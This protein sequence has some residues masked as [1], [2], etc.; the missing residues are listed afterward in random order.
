LRN[1]K[2]STEFTILTADKCIASVI[3]NTVD[4]KRKITSILEDPSHRRLARDPTES[5]EI[6]T[7]LLLKK[8]TVTDDISKQLRPSGSRP[9]I[10]YGLP[11]IHKEGVPLRPIVNNIGAPTYQLSKYLAGLLSQLTENSTHHVKKLLSV[12]SDIV[13]SKITTR[14][15]HV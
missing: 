4:Y 9:P 6:K 15:S 3:L 14:R 11:K 10:L 12:C 8:S 2:K 13:F 7:T 1:L 5:T